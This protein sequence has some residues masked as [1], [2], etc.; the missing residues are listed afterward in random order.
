M[1]KPVL[2]WSDGLIFLLTFAVAMFVRNIIRND[3]VRARW[4]KVFQTRVGMASF[5]VICV[6]LFIALLDSFHYREALP[7]T[8]QQT[9]QHYS[10]EIKSVLDLFLADLKANEEKTYSEPFAIYGFAKEN[11]QDK[12]GRTYRDFPRL[13][14]AGSHLADERDKINHIIWLSLQAL[15]F[16]VIACAFVIGP[17]WLWRR[18][19]SRDAVA[20]TTVVPIPWHVAYLTLSIFIL[21]A[22]WIYLVGGHYHI[23]GT[24]KVGTDVLYQSIKAIRTSVLIGTLATLLTLPLAVI[25]GVS[26]GYFKGWWDDVVQYIYTTLSSIPSILLIAAAALLVDVYI[27][28]HQEHFQLAIERADFKFL[29]LCMILGFTSWTSLCRLLRAE[30]LKVSQLDYIEAA[31]AFGVAQPRILYRH[32]LP[33]ITHI[34]LISLVLDF[35]GFVL[36]EAVLSYI[37]VGVDPAMNSWGNMI[38]AARTELSR[39]PTVWWSVTS[40]F[41]LMFTLVL[42]ANLFADR[43]RDA[44]DPR[45]A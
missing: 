28:T 35:S 25:L 43:V 33:N 30:T 29:A 5:V 19:S 10:H 1:I 44:F 16:G 39:D 41:I 45:M 34:I 13:E 23:L 40:A 42:A 27:Q 12:Q 26:A 21:I 11:M 3:L 8:S 15:V 17:H 7:E 14:H 6:Y 9:E 22:S 20:V 31:N 38:N 32:I 24:D 36:A 4:L 2:L 18:R 37:G